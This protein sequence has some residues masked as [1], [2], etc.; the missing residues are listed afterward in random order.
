[1]LQSGLESASDVAALQDDD[2]SRL[3]LMKPLHIRKL[4]RALSREQELEQETGFQ[5]VD[6]NGSF[7]LVEGAA[8]QRERF[9]TASSQM[10]EEGH[11]ESSAA[12]LLHSGLRTSSTRALDI[13][14]PFHDERGG[15]YL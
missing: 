7:G 6:A 4:R 13:E 2:L 9:R 5:P 15:M 8:S 1:M 11:F 14:A 12:D 3:L 10:D